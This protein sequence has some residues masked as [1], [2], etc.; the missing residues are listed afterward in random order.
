MT[1]V[2]ILPKDGFFFSFKVF[3]ENELSLKKIMPN[4]F[5]NFH[6]QWGAFVVGMQY[7]PMCQNLLV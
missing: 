1:Q 7:K 6:A 2:S 3:S 4:L 5:E